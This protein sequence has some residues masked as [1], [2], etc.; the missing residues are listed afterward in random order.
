MTDNFIVCKITDKKWAEKLLDGEVFMRPLNDFGGWN[1][2]QRTS[3]LKNH[4]RGDVLEGAAEIYGDARK[5]S[6]FDMFPEDLKEVM[7]SLYVIDEE[8]RYQKI[9]STYCLKINN[10]K[11]IKPDPKIKDF[12]DTVVVFVDFEQFIIRFIR[13]QLLNKN[14]KMFV[15][16]NKVKYF[17]RNEAFVSDPLFNKEDTHSYQNEL[18]LVFN[19]DNKK[20]NR[21]YDDLK[22]IIENIGSIRDIAF[23]MPIDKFLNVGIPRRVYKLF[24]TDKRDSVSEKLISYTKKSFQNYTCSKKKITFTI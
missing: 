11:E 8:A 13:K 16:L 19:S 12:G 14:E 18:R 2:C 7:S 1:V 24:Y 22:P 9:F 3:E 6:Y 20:L 10:K 4:F 5:S 23:S 15:L 21:K 17:K